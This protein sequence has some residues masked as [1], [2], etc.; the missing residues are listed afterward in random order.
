MCID[1]NDP[2]DRLLVLAEGDLQRGVGVER[3][4][5]KVLS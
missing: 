4:P 5:E 3:Y 1:L 2:L